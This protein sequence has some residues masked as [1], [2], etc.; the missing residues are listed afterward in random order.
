MREIGVRDWELVPVVSS[1]CVALRYF[2][3]LDFVSGSE[4]AVISG[5]IQRQRI[6]SG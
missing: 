5:A 4:K 1:P 2:A 3:S 6:D